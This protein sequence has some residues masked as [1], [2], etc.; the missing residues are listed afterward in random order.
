MLLRNICMLQVA[1]STSGGQLHA[2]GLPQREN[3][4]H[5]STSHLA[6]VVTG[7]VG[8]VRA[9]LQIAVGGS[10]TEGS[11]CS[12][13]HAHERWQRAEPRLADAE[14]RA[15]QADTEVRKLRASRDEQQGVRGGAAR[16]RKAH[17]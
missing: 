4:R 10:P 5:F 12:N 6:H 13:G 8:R 16:A 9:S 11:P 1:H 3:L 15:W 17:L 2:A 7:L 14:S